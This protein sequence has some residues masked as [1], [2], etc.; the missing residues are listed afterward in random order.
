MGKREAIK[1]IKEFI[2][3]LKNNN[4]RI[5][6]VYLFGS[7]AHNNAG[8]SSDIDVAVISPDFGKNYT[9]ES[10]FLMGIAQKIDLQISPEP[11]SVEEYKSASKGE[12]LWQEIIN[13]GQLIKA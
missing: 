11:Y 13:K 9:E 1:K 6:K 8:K 7:Y 5:E 3:Q 2:Q 4:V 12:F 10:L